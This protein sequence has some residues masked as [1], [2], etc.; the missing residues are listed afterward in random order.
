MKTQVAKEL[1][2]QGLSTERRSKM[3]QPRDLVLIGSPLNVQSI[4]GSN[5]TSASVDHIRV[6]TRCILFIPIGRGQEMAEVATS[7][8]HPPTSCDI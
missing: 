7:V 5:A 2:E 8:A 3:E 6:P 1:Q 4:Q